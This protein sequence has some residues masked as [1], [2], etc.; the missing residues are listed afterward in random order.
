MAKHEHPPVE[1]E[2]AAGGDVETARSVSAPQPPPSDAGVAADAAPS[3]QHSEPEDEDVAAVP[4][5]V[6]QDARTADAADGHGAAQ[7]VAAPEPAE[8]Q[9]EVPAA[10]RLVTTS[11]RRVARRPAGPPSGE[12][13]PAAETAGQT[14]GVVVADAAPEPGVTGPDDGV[15]AEAADRDSAEA[16]SPH[17]P[18]KKRGR[19]R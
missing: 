6:A 14:A 16:E 1:Q 9:P 3:P 18:V 12:Q 5:E 7:E 15:V 4:D 10:P 19:K 2:A 11:R 17:V 8:Q 13:A